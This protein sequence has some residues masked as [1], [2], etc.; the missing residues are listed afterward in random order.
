MN[1]SLT[2]ERD[3]DAK[4]AKRLLWQSIMLYKKAGMTQWEYIRMVGK[5]W[6]DPQGEFTKNEREKI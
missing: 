2:W 1:T 6:D 3:V 4:T 5:I